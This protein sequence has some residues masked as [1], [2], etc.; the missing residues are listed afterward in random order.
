M[1]P[2]LTYPGVGGGG[3]WA[4]DVHCLKFGTLTVL[5]RWAGGGSSAWTIEVFVFNLEACHISNLLIVFQI[6]VEYEGKR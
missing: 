2:E 1:R 5:S 4:S 6:S 3:P